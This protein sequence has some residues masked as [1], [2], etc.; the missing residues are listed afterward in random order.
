MNKLKLLKTRL[1][2][3][4]DPERARLLQGFFKTGPGE[5]AEGDVFLGLKVPVQRQIIKDFRDLSFAEIENLLSSPIHEYRLSA[6]L[7]LVSQ[8]ERGDE[9][10][11]EK[12]F[13]FY[14]THAARVNN[15]DL[16][17]VTCHK[18]V[19]AFL[20]ERNDFKI[21]FKLAQSKSL[22]ERRIAIVSTAMFIRERILA[23]TLQIAEILLHD[24]HDLIHKATGWMLRE[25][26]KKNEMALLD[27]LEKNVK[28]MPRVMLRYAIER[29][30]VSKQQLYL[31]R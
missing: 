9:I 23:P 12:I 1:N 2:T 24:K 17:D 27:F 31:R 10:A 11:K 20:L 14:L 6:L 28:L 5:Y 30:S 13:K 7:I 16:V 26:G 4:A 29:L 15:W 19:G 21:L 22:W 8:F 25:V 3:L 18:I